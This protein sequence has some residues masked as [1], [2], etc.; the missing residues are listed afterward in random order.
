MAPL[1]ENLFRAPI[2]YLIADHARIRRICDSLDLLARGEAR[3]IDRQV[4]AFSLAFL[5]HELPR[6]FRDEEEFLVP[7]V[8]RSWPPGDL[9]ALEKN[10]YSLQQQHRHDTS[11]SLRLLLPLRR[12]A[13][14]SA[15]GTEKE[16]A[17]SC[18]AL[19]V[20]LRRNL[21]WEEEAILRP[22]ARHLGASDLEAL[23]RA[24]AMRHGVAFPEFD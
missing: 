19:T 14:G 23:G 17:E 12:M 5:E 11:L 15:A 1:P 9:A 18:A 2:D 16:F 21:A 20:A 7:Q 4:A 8:R 24:M 6:H 10:L 13:A 3:Q 22:A